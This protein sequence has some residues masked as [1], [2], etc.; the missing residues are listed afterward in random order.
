MDKVETGVLVLYDVGEL[1]IGL[2]DAMNSVLGGKAS[3]VTLDLGMGSYKYSILTRITGCT[4]DVDLFEHW[5]AW[6]GA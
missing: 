2:M 3:A 5:S 1:Q 4:H 6:S